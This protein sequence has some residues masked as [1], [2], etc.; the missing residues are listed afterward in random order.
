MFGLIVI[1]YSLDY[2]I[3]T[4]GG[5]GRVGGGVS[6]Q[7]CTFSGKIQYTMHP[8]WIKQSV[9]LC[10]IQLFSSCYSCWS[11]I[12]HTQ[13]GPWLCAPVCFTQSL[14]NQPCIC[15]ADRCLDSS[16]HI[17]CSSYKINVSKE[18][19]YLPVCVGMVA[20]GGNGGATLCSVV[21]NESCGITG[22]HYFQI[23]G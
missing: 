15:S 12:P 10:G 8:T 5:E 13:A 7:W 6:E 16:S 21:R 9:T 11:I 20:L 22:G 1:F 2:Q 19:Y 14:I 17:V 4:P 3:Q 23:M 18:R